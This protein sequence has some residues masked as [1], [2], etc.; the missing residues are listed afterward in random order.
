[1]GHGRR[2]LGRGGGL[3]AACGGGLLAVG[4]GGLWAGGGGRW[5]GGGGDAAPPTVCAVSTATTATRR[6]RARAMG[7]AFAVPARAD[8]ARL[9]RS[10][11]R[12][13]GTGRACWGPAC[14]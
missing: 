6:T 2:G 5:L 10:A 3:A 9:T 14:R 4:G 11:F 8:K 13:L 12:P 7:H 1:M